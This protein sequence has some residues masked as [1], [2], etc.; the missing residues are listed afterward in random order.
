M[1]NSSFRGLPTCNPVWSPKTLKE[2]LLQH[3]QSEAKTQHPTFPPNYASREALSKVQ[4]QLMDKDVEEF[5]QQSNGLATNQ[6]WLFNLSNGDKD[7]Y[8]LRPQKL[9]PGLPMHS[10]GNGY[11]HS[12]IQQSK[13]DSK[14]AD[15]DRGANRL[16][17]HFPDLC[18]VF[19]PQS[20]IHSPCFD[21]A[22]E[23]H[24]IQSG[25]K[26]APNEQNVPLDINQMVSSFQ[27]FMAGEHDGLSR[28]DF[29]NMHKQTFGM[30]H[31]DGMVEQWKIAAPAVSTQST[32]A[33]QTPK[34]LVGEF[35]IAQMERNG[36]V[37]KQTF[38]HNAFQA[39]PAFSS[40]NTEYLQQPEPLSASVKLPNQ[41]KNKMSIQR[42]NMNQF[43]K[44]HIQ[45]DQLQNKPQMQ[46]EK[47]MMQMSGFLG[48]GVS[49]RPPTNIRMR[50]GDKKQV[51]S[52]SAHFDLQGGMQSQ[53]F[54]GENNMIN[55]GN[56][57]QCMPYIYPICDFRERPGI[58]FNSNLGSRSALPYENGGPGVDVCDVSGSE[59]A[60]FKSR[61]SDMM[62]RGGESTY[63]GMASG[64]ITSMV[65]NQGGPMIRLYF[66]LDECYEQWRGL[67]KERKRVCV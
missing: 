55:A 48:E 30:L 33:M 60:A 63:H 61:V 35:G 22:Y 66:S 28:R 39:L 1:L 16:L 67:E 13:Y 14:P 11:S 43:S 44:H 27:S 23:D 37:R 24:Y 32:P 47:M 52:Q 46:R 51:Y 45:Q 54:N 58:P 65:M 9:P 29:P 40:Q 38:K 8:T 15:K 36:G 7:G 20:E 4:G 53:R 21:P 56:A 59:S 6:Q 18:D 41:Y 42:E 57:Q 19:R 34:Q 64:L 17:N 12:Q 49:T 62:R 50:E 3:F 10:M 31:E 26:S 5:C 25:A 2:E